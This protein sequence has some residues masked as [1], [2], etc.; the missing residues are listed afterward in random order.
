MESARFCTLPFSNR[1]CSKNWRIPGTDVVLPK[2][3]RVLYS[4][5]GPHFDDDYFPD[6][7]RFDPDRFSPENKNDPRTKV[8]YQP[9]GR[10]PRKCLGI[11]IAK[12]ETKVLLFHLVKN[13]LL[14]P[15]ADL[16]VPLQFADE[17]GVMGVM[18]GVK[19]DVRER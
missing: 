17:V 16:V 5:I 9:F 4:L 11:D 1:L 8:A 6:P 13:F 18:G 19:V 3:M 7:T 14:E 2:G 15:S 10:G 12:M